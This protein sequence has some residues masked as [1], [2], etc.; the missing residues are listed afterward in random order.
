MMP[1]GI[2]QGSLLYHAA[3]GLCCVKQ[4]S[5]QKESGKNALFYALEPKATN[6]MKIRFLVPASGMEA[7]GF[8]SLVPTTVA[9]RI[10]KYLKDGDTSTLAQECT[11]EAACLAREILTFSHGD[12]T[13]KDQR[14]RQRM[15]R[16]VHGL[17][18]E[19]SV[20][21]KQTTKD[22]AKMIQKSLGDPSKINPLVVSAL[23]N[24]GDI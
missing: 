12:K 24:A 17:V 5:Q 15:E 13:V 23:T 11:H 14:N 22:T 16:L 6:K 18:G 8:H 4:L 9:N 19:L 1:T 21:L 7:S 20:V 10:M 3:H 2:V